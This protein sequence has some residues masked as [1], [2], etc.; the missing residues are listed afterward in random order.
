MF[1]K[2]ARVGPVACRHTKT[3]ALRSAG[4]ERLVCETCGHVSFKATEEIVHTPDRENFAR[5]S[6]LAE[7]SKRPAG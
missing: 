7:D 6:D 4:L 5:D 3:V 2:R 1:N